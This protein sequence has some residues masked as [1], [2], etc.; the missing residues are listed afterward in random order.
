MREVPAYDTLPN[1]SEE[2]VR[3]LFTELIDGGLVGQ[4]PGQYP[5]V[6][7]TDLGREVLAGRSEVAV[8]LPEEPVVNGTVSFVQPLDEAH[9]LAEAPPDTPT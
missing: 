7:L 6:M 1:W 8:S 3:R 5:M 9:V 2:R 4:T